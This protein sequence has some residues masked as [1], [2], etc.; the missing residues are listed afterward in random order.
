MTDL[1]NETVG[2][3][4]AEIERIDN[5]IETLEGMPDSESVGPYNITVNSRLDQLQA[6]R[7]RVMSRLKR[8][9]ARN[10]RSDGVDPVGINGGGST[11]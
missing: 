10:D 4:E 6:R 7:D 9:R 5:R 1:N 11:I 8:L 3:L 2:N